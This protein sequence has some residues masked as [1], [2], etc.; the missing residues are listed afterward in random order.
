[1]TGLAVTRIPPGLARA[2]AE[3]RHY[4]HRKP[5]VS[6]SF[7][8]QDG[9]RLAGI[10]VFGIPASHELRK[11]ACPEHPE[12]VIE[13]NRLW[14]DDVMPRNTGSWFVS[15][16]LA[17]IPP[18]IVV[19]YADTIQG[20]MGYIYRALNFRYAGWTDMERK[21]PR[22]DYMP[23][24]A[25]IHTRDAYRNGYARKVRR[26]PKVKYWTVTGTRADKRR[27]AAACGWPS[28]DW[29]ELPP[30]REHR[31]YR[32]DREDAATALTA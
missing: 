14:V 17:R 8:L 6:Y 27:L 12:W 16:C 25:G 7:G 20:H 10:C 18:F 5:P 24:R 9:D 26:R 31:Q 4:M 3:E 19:S 28:L 32:P 30:P 2:V 29:N 15:R 11:G 22:L 23:E 1:V 13:F 21:T